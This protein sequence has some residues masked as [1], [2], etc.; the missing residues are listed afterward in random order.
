MKTK[1]LLTALAISFLGFSACKNHEKAVATN[2]NSKQ[3]NQN[4]TYSLVVSFISIGQGVDS[5][6]IEKYNKFIAQFEQENNVKINI[7]KVPWVE[8]VKL[9]IVLI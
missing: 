8:K 9:I 4:N 2:Q 6:A 3:M 1:L 5:K 7:E